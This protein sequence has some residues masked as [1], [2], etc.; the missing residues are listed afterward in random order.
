MLGD[1]HEGRLAGWIDGHVRRGAARP[2]PCDDPIVLDGEADGG[3]EGVTGGVQRDTG[4]STRQ[5]VEGG[6]DVEAFGDAF[7]VRGAKV[8]AQ[9]VEAARGKATN[10]ASTTTLNRSPPR[11][12]WGGR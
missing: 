11:N 1:E 6:D 8:E 5:M 2:R 9:G 12:G 4:V 3:P 10:I 7:A